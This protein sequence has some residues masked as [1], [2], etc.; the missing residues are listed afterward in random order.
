MNQKNNMNISRLPNL[1]NSGDLADIELIISDDYQTINIQV[2]RLIL[3]LN[4]DYFQRMFQNWS[5]KEKCVINIQ[6]PNASICHDII[7]SF[8]GIESNISDLSDF[9]YNLEMIKCK[10]F[11]N[12]NYDNNFEN[13]KNQHQLEQNEIVA[14]INIIDIL[15]Y[16]QVIMDKILINLNEDF[17][18]ES[19][20]KTLLHYIYN[21]LNQSFII[22]CDSKYNIIIWN[23][24]GSIINKL[25]TKQKINTISLSKKGKQN[26]ILG[27]Y[28]NIYA[29]TINGQFIKSFSEQ[30]NLIMGIQMISNGDKLVSVDIKCNLIVWNF[31]TTEILGKYNSTNIKSGR[32][33]YIFTIS[34]N[35]QYAI[36]GNE[37]CEKIDLGSASLI[38][39]IG[40]DIDIRKIIW[41]TALTKDNKKLFV[42]MDGFINIYNFE[43][44]QKIKSFLTNKSNF[45]ICL[46][47]NE[48]D[49]LIGTLH[50]ILL[51]YD[52]KFGTLKSEIFC[53]DIG[54][55]LELSFLDDNN[56]ICV[57][58]SANIIPIV[59]IYKL[60][61]LTINH[62]HIFRNII[63]YP[64]NNIQH[65][66]LKN[67]LF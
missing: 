42:A 31:N 37:S 15:K 51:V 2:H 26:I 19:M 58:S 34:S 63:K 32:I 40:I 41:S 65:E 20:D 55:I 5:E 1:Y 39:N 16:D 45:S 56:V 67:I 66:K 64:V 25:D 6:V 21:S 12:I 48:E 18:I 10:D 53:G 33:N 3:Y 17:N 29:W 9:N 57:G 43:T 60:S 38:N 22:S 7:L 44:G 4:C 36:I 8:Y 23:L 54:S 50:G 59:N 62:K 47:S 49:L 28:L 14:L 61:I 35:E 27:A 11:F 30:E 52:I 46:S 13:I 24:N